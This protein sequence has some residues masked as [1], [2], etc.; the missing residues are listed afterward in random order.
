MKVN[1]VIESLLNDEE[2]SLVPKVDLNKVIAEMDWKGLVDRIRTEIG[3]EVK[4]L[5][6]ELVNNER[7]T[8]ESENI[9][10]QAGVMKSVLKKLTVKNFNSQL[11]RDKKR[12]WLVVD[13]RYESYSG[14]NGLNIFEAYW[15]IEK[16]EWEFVNRNKG[17]NV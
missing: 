11:S 16:K 12:Y 14:S 6:P 1:N 3:Y 7:I 15:D 4:S 2:E 9:V 17:W 5:N 10:D 13:F 8:F